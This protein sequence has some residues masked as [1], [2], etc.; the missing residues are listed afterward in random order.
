MFRAKKRRAVTPIK[1]SVRVIH[2]VFL[3][4]DCAYFFQSPDAILRDHTIKNTKANN[5][6]ISE[7]QVTEKQRPIPFWQRDLKMP[8]WLLMLLISLA[9]VV[10]TAFLVFTTIVTLKKETNDGPCKVNS[11]C[12]QDRGL[13]CNNYRCGCGYSHFWSGTYLTC[14][15][16]RMINRTCGND[17]MCDILASLECF[18]VTLAYVS[19]G[20]FF[21]KTSFVCFVEMEIFKVNVNVNHRRVGMEYQ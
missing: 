17:S 16:R 13:M 12:R 11:D 15:R 1:T 5:M 21:R 6:L 4:K 10:F 2:L 18:N 3:P 14:E 9:I 7:Y 19:F 20:M 8:Q